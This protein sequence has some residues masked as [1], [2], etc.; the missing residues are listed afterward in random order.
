VAPGLNPHFRLS[1]D[2]QPIFT[3]RHRVGTRLPDIQPGLS[4][5]FLIAT[6]VTPHS[7][8]LLPKRETIAD[9][10]EIPPETG[11]SLEPTP[12]A[13]RSA[14]DTFENEANPQGRFVQDS[15]TLPRQPMTVRP[16]KRSGQTPSRCP[17]TC[18]SRNGIGAVGA[19]RAVAI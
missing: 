4:D 6:N 2:K 12:L 5:I 15:C 13:L 11:A 16:S 18:L 3:G 1:V 10:L 14:V 17:P 9:L 8:S 19:V 7:A